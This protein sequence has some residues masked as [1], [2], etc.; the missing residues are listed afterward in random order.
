MP[1]PWGLIVMI[2][3]LTLL[4]A[5]VMWPG[6]AESLLR[7]LLTGLALV[8]VVVWA[9]RMGLPTAT[10]HDAYS[11]FGAG[12]AD[13]PPITI[14]E[15]VRERAEALAVCDDPDRARASRIPWPIARGLLGEAVR[16]LEAEHGLR[17]D[18]PGH[19]ARIRSMVS[20]PTRVLLGLDGT[21]G[22]RDAPHPED[23]HVPLAG[24]DDILDDLERL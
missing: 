13:A 9:L 6:I 10:V 15:V 5:G 21:A 7:V 12:V 20:E 14:P 4:A 18:D 22:A 2:A 23:R 1:G 17:L 11:P 3:S 19:A 16:R 8:F 24:L